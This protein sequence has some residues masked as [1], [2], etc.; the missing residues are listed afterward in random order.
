[1]DLIQ[2]INLFEKLYGSYGSLVVFI[3]SFVEIT[4]FGFLVPG[5]LFLAIGGFFS[6]GGNIHL[7]SIILPGFFGAWLTF[8]LAYFLGKKSGA[9]FIRRF[10]QEKNARVARHLLKQHGGVILTASMM[11]NATRF[12]VAYIAGVENYNIKKYLFYSA[13]ASLTWVSLMT[14]LGYVA[15][16]ERETLERY[17]ATAGLIPWVILIIVLVLISKLVRKMETNENL[18][19]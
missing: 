8:L 19:N 10:K 5:G 11:A 3:G 2:A 4:P 1:M 16:S 18:G 12:M 9:T 14:V 17:V 7:L 6:Y 15:G 13:T